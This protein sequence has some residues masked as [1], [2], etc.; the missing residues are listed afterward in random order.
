MDDLDGKRLHELL[1][2]GETLMNQA[3]DA[4]RKYHKAK[5]VLPNDQVELLR[6]EAESL[7]QAV[8]AY[9]LR[10]LG[11]AAPPLQ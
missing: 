1:A 5:G 7:F 10:A 4:L 6:L 11:G 9:Q 2:Q 8:S 3:M